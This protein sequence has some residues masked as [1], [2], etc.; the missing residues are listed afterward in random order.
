[1]REALP[2]SAS[3]ATSHN[4]VGRKVLLYVGRLAK[5]KRVDRL[6]HAFLSISTTFADATLVI[7]GDGPERESLQ[8]IVSAAGVSERVRFVGHCEGPSLFGWFNLGTLF[9]LTSEFE[10]WGAVINEALIS[11][12]P[13]ICSDV[14][15][16][17][18]LI[19]EGENG[20]VINAGHRNELIRALSTWLERTGPLD[21]NQLRELRA[22]L[23][24]TSFNEAVTG[25]LA[26][27][28]RLFCESREAT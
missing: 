3:L 15:G 9:A 24:T 17:S 25:F 27:V 6:L 21:M 4:L 22:S 14:A 1:L 7:V 19:S 18:E 8:R 12:I 26:P 13:V 10:P 2:V 16:A 11:G 5:V 20:A 28:I 23:M